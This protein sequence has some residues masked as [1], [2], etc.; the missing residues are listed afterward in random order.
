MP[1]F[2]KST[3]IKRLAYST[4]ATDDKSACLMNGNP[5]HFEVTGFQR[6]QGAF[7]MTVAFILKTF[8]L[9]RLEGR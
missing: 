5:L 6:D 4:G 8:S 1:L 2:G 7:I 3:D 9:T